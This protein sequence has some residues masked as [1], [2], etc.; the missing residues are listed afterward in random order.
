[1]PS[2]SSVIAILLSLF[3]RAYDRRS[4]HGPNLRGSLR[5]ISAA[6][7]AWRPIGGGHNVW[8]IAVHAAY[9]KYVVLR[10]LTGGKRGAFGR[11]GS[12]WFALPSDPTEADWKADLAL[13]EATHRALRGAIRRVDAKT[14][15]R[16]LPGK[17]TSRSELISGAAAHDVYH[18]GQI[19][20]I[21]RMMPG[22][23]GGASGRRE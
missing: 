18:A 10:A 22:R 19:Q 20:L 12:N 4:W 5:G 23:R 14:L 16:P 13:L 11:R 3:D 15:E 1:M 17:K 21:K 6:D 7:A 8:E 9:W 2:E